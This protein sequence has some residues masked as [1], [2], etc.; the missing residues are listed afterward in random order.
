LIQDSQDIATR[1]DIKYLWTRKPEENY[2]G[3]KE[4][5]LMS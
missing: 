1:E 5:K 2:K 3:I 4:V